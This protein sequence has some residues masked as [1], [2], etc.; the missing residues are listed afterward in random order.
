MT[1][2]TPPQCANSVMSA[3]PGAAASLKVVLLDAASYPGQSSYLNETWVFTG[4]DWTDTSTALVNSNSPLP[5]RNNAC[6]AYDGTNVVLFG[7]QGGSAV[8]GVLADTWV[9]SSAGQTWSQSAP[10][11]SPS[12][13]FG[14]AMTNLNG[15]GAMM[16]GGTNLLFN[17]LETWTWNGT[18]WSLVSVAN[19]AGPAARTGHV[20]AGDAGGTGTVMMFGGQGT[21][22][23]FNDTW[24]Y[25]TAGGW[26]LVTPTTTAPSVRSG[27]CMAYDTAGSRWVMFGGSNEYGYLDETWT[28]TLASATSGTWTKVAVANGAGPAGRIGAQMAYDS[29]SGLVTMFGGQTATAGYPSNETWQLS[30]TTWVQ[31]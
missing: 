23:Q 13:R 9:W 30:G 21:N 29:Q 25:T 24:S 8:V 10:A 26:S 3:D 6:M 31:L 4:T 12:G 17:L 16:F 22:Q 7:G 11:T 15:T 5:G 18:T 1:T 14:A 27:A 28:F 20:M 19:G 2:H